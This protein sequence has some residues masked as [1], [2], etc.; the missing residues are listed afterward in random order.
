MPVK[1]GEGVL[2]RSSLEITGRYGQERGPGCR[3]RPG[4]T[5]LWR[6]PHRQP[7]Q[8]FHLWHTLRG[9]TFLI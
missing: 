2:G 8:V 5:C 9:S 3:P 7:N 4:H 6:L 1:V